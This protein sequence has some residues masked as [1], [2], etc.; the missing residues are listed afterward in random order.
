MEKRVIEV[1]RNVR[2]FVELVG[3]EKITH[4]LLIVLCTAVYLPLNTAIQEQYLDDVTQNEKSVEKIRLIIAV[5][6]MLT[7]KL[8]GLKCQKKPNRLIV[9]REHFWHKVPRILRVG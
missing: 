1:S 9:S 4:F 3:Q 6:I 7:L 8:F 2:K 5:K